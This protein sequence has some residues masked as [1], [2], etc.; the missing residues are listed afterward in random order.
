MKELVD[1]IEAIRN[2]VKYIHSSSARLDKFR[3]YVVLE[4]KDKMST[5]P[6]DVVTRWNATYIMLH[7][8]YKFKGVF[9]RLVEEFTLFKSYFEEGRVGPPSD[10]DWKKA[11]GFAHF[12]KKFY[13]ATVKLSATKTPTS[14]IVL[15]ILINLKIEIEARIID[16]KKVVLQNLATSMKRKF[17]K[18]WGSF[19]DMNMFMFVAQTLDPRYKFQLM[20]LQ[21]GGLGYTLDE[22]EQLKSRV[23]IHLYLM[24]Q[25]YKGTEK[26]HVNVHED[27]DDGVDLGDDDDIDDDDVELRIERRLN[28]QRK[29]AKLKEIANEVDKMVNALVCTNDWLRGE[30]FQ[31]HKEPTEEELEFYMELEQLE[32]SIPNTNEMP[33]PLSKTKSA[34]PPKSRVNKLSSHPSRGGKGGRG[35]SNRGGR[36]GGATSSSKL[37]DEE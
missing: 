26:S 8:A 1:S 4:K 18:Y 6:M 13:D 23:K 30:E 10:E 15:K 28:R 31:F 19:E 11:M 35:R 20:E 5:I 16:K 37:I 32:Q 34:N 36:G 24:Y 7:G 14:H 9:A 33:P 17:D 2:C 21:L 3:E 22:V 27:G 12:L 25:T 29:E